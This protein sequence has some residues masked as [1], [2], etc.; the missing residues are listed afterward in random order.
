[1]ELSELKN[2]VIIAVSIA[3]ISCTGLRVGYQTGS[4]IGRTMSAESSDG[5]EYL[6]LVSEFDGGVRDILAEYGDPAYVTIADTSILYFFYPDTDTIVLLNR[7]A[8]SPHSVPTELAPIPDQYL[9]H[10]GLAQR[11][12]IEEKRPP[13]QSGESLTSPQAPQ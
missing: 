6:K 7:G 1:M 2:Q 9:N 5:V 4:N 3:L 11:R 13:L 10:L 8:F 12:R